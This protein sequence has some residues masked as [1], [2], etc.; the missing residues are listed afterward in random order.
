M[1]SVWKCE[2]IGV[3]LEAILPTSL[4]TSRWR[5]NS[6][7]PLTRHEPDYDMRVLWSVL[8][9]P[10]TCPPV[11]RAIGQNRLFCGQLWD[12]RFDWT[13]DVICFFTCYA[14]HIIRRHLELKISDNG[15][16][17]LRGDSFSGCQKAA[18]LN[19]ARAPTVCVTDVYYSRHQVTIV[20]AVPRAGCLTMIRTMASSSRRYAHEKQT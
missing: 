13:Y 14:G 12:A 1:H 2:N 7:W 20:V 19:V 8:I 5:N 15:R 10:T 4:P 16:L 11:I 6:W 17:N 3:F 18:M 9:V